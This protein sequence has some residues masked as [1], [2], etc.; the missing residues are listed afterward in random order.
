M[1][2]TTTHTG[3]PIFSALTPGFPLSLYP[4]WCSH[5]YYYL[6]SLHP[7]CSAPPCSHWSAPFLY[8]TGAFLS[9]PNTTPLVLGTECSLPA[10]FILVLS[11]WVSPTW[12]ALRFSLQYAILTLLTWAS[13]PLLGCCECSSVYSWFNLNSLSLTDWFLCVSAVILYTQRGLTWHLTRTF[14]IP[15]LLGSPFLF[16]CSHR[17]GRYAAVCVPEFLMASLPIY[18]Y[19]LGRHTLFFFFCAGQSS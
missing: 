15:S 9:S 16:L 10:L 12:W 13:F 8:H 11:S 2:L 19:R 7:Y 5:P 18:T 3:T 17:I 14:P 4:H 6:V 1:F